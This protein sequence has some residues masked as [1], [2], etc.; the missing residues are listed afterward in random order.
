MK[1]KAEKDRRLG[2]QA[3]HERDEFERIIGVQ[4]QQ[5]V[6]EK[7]KQV[8]QKQRRMQHVEELRAQIQA[9]EEVAMQTRKTCLEEGKALKSDDG[10]ERRK[11]EKIK[12]KKLEE[13]KKIGVPEKYWAELAKKK[14]LA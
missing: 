14:I 8:E 5:E 1:Q 11:L 3:R 6:A 9:R 7:Q 4:M 2:E 10:T 13:L 12:E